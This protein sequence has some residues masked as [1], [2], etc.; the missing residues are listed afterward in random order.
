MKGLNGFRGRLNRDFRILK[1]FAGFL[2]AVR[3]DVRP[4]AFAD[5]LNQDLRRLKD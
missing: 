3:R 2:I 5:C 4:C 1:K